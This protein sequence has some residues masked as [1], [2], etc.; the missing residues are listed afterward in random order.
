MGCQVI[1]TCDSPINS[2]GKIKISFQYPKFHGHTTA[3]KQQCFLSSKEQCRTSAIKICLIRGLYWTT[4]RKTLLTHARRAQAQEEAL[5]FFFSPAT[6]QG[7]REWLPPICCRII[8]C[9]LAS[10]LVWRV[11]ASVRWLQLSVRSQSHL[12][13]GCMKILLI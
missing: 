1:H 8:S 3:M 4:R 6:N 10:W 12:C 9:S 7:F 13:R 5:G 11:L 2:L